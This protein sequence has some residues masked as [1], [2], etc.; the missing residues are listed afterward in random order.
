MHHRLVGSVNDQV[1][2][3]QVIRAQAEEVDVRRHQVACLSSRRC[4]DHDSERNSA[5]VGLAPQVKLTANFSEH[6]PRG[7]QIINGRDEGEKE[8]HR[9]A[10]RRTVKCSKLL[11]ENVFVFKTEPQASSAEIQIHS[12]P[13][14][15]IDS[16]VN[17][18]EG[19]RSAFGSLQNVGIILQ[20]RVFVRLLPFTEEVELGSVEANRF[21]TIRYY[22]LNFST[23]IDVLTQRNTNAIFGK[24]AAR[25]RTE[26]F[27]TLLFLVAAS[28]PVLLQRFFRWRPDHQTSTAV[29]N[30][31]IT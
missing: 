20:Q 1:V 6:F 19:Y 13:G 11:L 21:A 24:A 12:L 3:N 26:R 18:T 10:G 4:L 17:R 7:I 28:I 8:A 27:L 16:H 23:K 2:L 9:A 5:I 29:D 22:R 15:L 30:K 31:E 14:L 25:C